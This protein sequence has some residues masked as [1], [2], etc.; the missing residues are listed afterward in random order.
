MSTVQRRQE[1]LRRRKRRQRIKLFCNILVM[2]VLVGIIGK[3][4]KTIM[5]LVSEQSENITTT[6]AADGSIRDIRVLNE[7]EVEERLAELSPEDADIAQ[8][9]ANRDAYPEALLKALA[10]NPEMTE[11]VKGYLTSDG[12]VTG[13]ITDE[14][15]EQEFPLFLQWDERWGYAPY[16]E[17]NIGI[18][19]CGP[20]CLSMVIFALTNDESATPDKLADYSMQNGYYVSGTGT[21]WTL[22]TEAPAAYGIAATELGLDEEE[23][24]RYLDR[25]CPIICAMRPGDFTTTGH[26]IV[27]YGYDENGFMVNDPNSRERSSRRWTFDTLQYQIK[28]LW[29][30]EKL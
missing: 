5:T 1:R 11:F 15:K 16:G 14:E 30:Y 8:I 22:M 26:F 27:I 9:Y 13:G 12:S 21:A 3:C 10:N 25:G 29:A 18:S 7:E 20:T 6:G 28:N 19:G 24:E 2:V 23:M 4:G 17:S